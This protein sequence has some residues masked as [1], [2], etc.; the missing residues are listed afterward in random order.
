MLAAMWESGRVVA[1]QYA[2]LVDRCSIECP[3]TVL[4]LET[5]LA[6]A[7]AVPDYSVRHE[8]CLAEW[9]SREED[10]ASV[11]TTS[12]FALLSS[13]AKPSI[14]RFWQTL[15][16]SARTAIIFGDC[17]QRETVMLLVFGKHRC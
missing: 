7:L 1:V 8:S 12:V 5:R 3:R 11:S 17:H 10:F 2:K 4:T 14:P 15:P 6:R 16:V 13:G 9:I